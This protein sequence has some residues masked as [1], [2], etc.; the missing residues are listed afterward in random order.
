MRAVRLDTKIGSVPFESLREEARNRLE[1]LELEDERVYHLRLGGKGGKRRVWG[2]LYGNVF[3]LIWW[4]PK[5][6]IARG[7]DR[8]R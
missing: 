5:H 1:E 2:L 3:H 8:R 4:D 6:Q 7:S